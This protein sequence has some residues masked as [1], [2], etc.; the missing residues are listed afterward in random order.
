MIKPSIFSLMCCIFLLVCTLLP[1]DVSAFAIAPGK[2]VL[3]FT[4]NAVAQQEIL[5]FNTEQ[6]TLTLTLEAIGD[7]APYIKLSKTQVTLTPDTS[8]MI[9]YTL[10]LPSGFPQSGSITGMIVAHQTSKT[11]SGDSSEIVRVGAV[12][13]VASLIQV[14]VPYQGRT[15]EA[16]VYVAPT[17]AYQPVEFLAQAKN[18]GTNDISSLQMRIAI[19]DTENHL[20]TTLSSEEQKL[21]SGKRT[22]IV[23]VW[24]PHILYG[25]YHA[26]ITFL[27]NGRKQ[28]TA[29]D[30]TVGRFPVELTDLRIEHFV[31]GSQTNIMLLLTNKESRD[32]SVIT[33]ITLQE[34][35]LQ[36]S[37]SLDSQTL[38]LLSEQDKLLLFTWNL[39][40]VA[41]GTYQG[42]VSLTIEDTTAVRN[43]Y[44]TLTPEGASA[45]FA[46]VQSITGQIIFL[47]PTTDPSRSNFSATLVLVILIVLVN[48]FL[49]GFWYYRRRK[50]ASE[51]PPLVESTF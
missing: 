13:S 10:R 32:I 35:S 20:L 11:F 29:L 51:Q 47:D 2:T 45:S 12:A 1:I 8:V 50:K 28:E 30:F 15:L 36:Y 38:T 14:N 5:L 4:P 22:D 31:F 33:N 3:E 40:D 34:D 43:F 42:E 21:A 17:D 16:S 44:I 25:D 41:L 46:P 37:T 23:T 18:V 6:Q 39:T 24:D 49:F 26:V 7:L 48:I 9:P 27:Y 19:Y